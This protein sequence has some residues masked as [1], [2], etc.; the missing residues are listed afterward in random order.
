MAWVF[1]Q[2]LEKEKEKKV[3]RIV[4][5]EIEIEGDQI[6]LYCDLVYFNTNSVAIHDWLNE[7]RTGA[8]W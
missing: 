6:N 5:R 7:I 4:A 2:L 1:N 8:D 3:S